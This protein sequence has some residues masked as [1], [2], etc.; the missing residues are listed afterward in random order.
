M[1]VSFEDRQHYRLSVSDINPFVHERWVSI[2]KLTITIITA[3]TR[4]QNKQENYRLW[5]WANGDSRCSVRWS[6]LAAA[7]VSDVSW[8]PWIRRTGS[9]QTHINNF[10]III[11][12]NMITIT[13][14]TT[15]ASLRLDAQLLPS[16]SH[17]LFDP[18]S[19][20]H[21]SFVEYDI[22]QDIGNSFGEWILTYVCAMSPN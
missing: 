14:I 13:M 15:A 10:N 18:L 1:D 19:C 9:G 3:N 22:S 16:F 5:K 4:W 12:Y 7:W 20:V 21:D 11:W 17:Y 6:R 2:W 8:A